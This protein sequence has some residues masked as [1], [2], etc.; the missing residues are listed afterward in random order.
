MNTGRDAAIYLF[1]LDPDY[2]YFN[3]KSLISTDSA[4][5]YEGNA[6]VNKILHLAQNMYIGKTGKKLL[7]EDFYAYDNGGILLDVQENYSFLLSIKDKE[8]FSLDE[9]IRDYLYKVFLMLKDAPIKELIAI[10]HEDPAWIEKHNNYH[11]ADQKMD[12]LKFAEDYQSRYEAANF[13]LEHME[14]TC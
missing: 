5:F 8:K 2:V 10:D 13:Y 11:K 6:R 4:T 3:T 7:E 1:S 12:S 14:P 9:N